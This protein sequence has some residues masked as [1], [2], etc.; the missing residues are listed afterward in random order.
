MKKIIITES[1]K[2]KLVNEAIGLGF[3]FGMLKSLKSFKGRFNY[4]KEYL[5]MVIGK[6]SSRVVFQIDDEWVLKLAMNKKGIAQNEVEQQLCNDNYQ[7]ITPNM[8]N[9]LSDIDD[10]KFI[11]SEYVIPASRNDFIN[12]F[13]ITPDEFFNFITNVVRKHDICRN[14]MT[15]N[16]REYSDEEFSEMCEKEELLDFY[17]YLTNYYPDRNTLADM[18]VLSNYGIVNRNG[19]PKIV[20]LDSGYNEDVYN[21]FYKR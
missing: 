10:Y 16:Y 13:G 21:K 20:L 18:Q 19:E 12:I 11:V 17:D 6:G 7:D 14:Y 1:Q 2:K 9:K 15:F 3:S 8:N 4:C 5:G